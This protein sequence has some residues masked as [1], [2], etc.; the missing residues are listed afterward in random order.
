[1][2][3]LA[4]KKVRPP[5]KKN[6]RKSQNRYFYKLIHAFS[7]K[8]LVKPKEFQHLSSKNIEIAYKYNDF[9]I[10]ALFFGG[11]GAELSFQPG[12][13]LHSSLL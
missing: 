12:K 6:G 5:K 3:L 11:G 4:G 1:V 8:K 9:V 2:G 7:I 13:G 10:L